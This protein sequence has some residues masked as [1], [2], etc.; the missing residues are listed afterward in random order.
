[1]LHPQFKKGDIVW[2]AHHNHRS[3]ILQIVESFQPYYNHPDG[4]PESF[5]TYTYNV[6]CSLN[7]TPTGR[8][9]YVTEVDLEK[10][11]IIDL[12]ELHKQTCDA[13]NTINNIHKSNV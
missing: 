8:Y 6:L 5:I 1:M 3:A 2:Y 4:F 12:L 7:N 10:F 13:I 11:D 9:S